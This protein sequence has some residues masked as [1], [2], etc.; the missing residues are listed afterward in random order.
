MANNVPPR[1][2]VLHKLTELLEGINPLNG[3]AYNLTESVFRGRALFG[4]EAP[5]TWLNIIESP[6]PDYGLFVGDDQGRSEGWVL[7]LQGYTKLPDNKHPLDELYYLAAEVENRLAAIVATKADGSG[8]PAFPDLYYL[9]RD[10]SGRTLIT[11]IEIGPP[12]VRPASE[13]SNKA[14]FYLALRVGVAE[15]WG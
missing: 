7:L 6:R 15:V 9:G 11:G 14:S 4:E 1:L 10:A 8:R 13:P 5:D 12:V 3:Y 2:L